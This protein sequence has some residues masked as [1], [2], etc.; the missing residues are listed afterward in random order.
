M[1]F[2]CWI[3]FNV[4][5]NGISSFVKK[6]I[7]SQPFCINIGFW[8]AYFYYIRRF[9]KT[10]FELQKTSN[11]HPWIW[12][13]EHS[14]L[15]ESCWRDWNLHKQQKYFTEYLAEYSPINLQ[16]VFKDLI[17]SKEKIVKIIYQIAEAIKYIHNK[18]II[19]RDLKPANI[20]ITSNGTVKNCHFG[21][22]KLLTVE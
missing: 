18:K 14:W 5:Y 13:H 6:P 22:S 15:S 4:W 19:H 3:L 8:L 12:N 21:I 11:F 17:I 10:I 1:N 7:I 9:F 2:F 20:L 16:K